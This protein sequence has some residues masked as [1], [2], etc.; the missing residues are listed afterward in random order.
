MYKP[1]NTNRLLKS[2]PLVASAPKRTASD[3]VQLGGWALAE[4]TCLTDSGGAANCGGWLK[5][6]F[7]V[8]HGL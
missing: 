1:R 3:I 5:F 8:P 4:A 7:L 2:P 6:I